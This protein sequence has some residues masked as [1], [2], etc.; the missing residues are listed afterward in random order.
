MELHLVEDA[1]SESELRGP[2]AVD[3]HVLVARSLLGTSHRSRDVVHIG[4]QW[5]LPQV[6]G[7]CG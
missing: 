4:D 1:G 3:E 5:P 7:A 2:G 6:G